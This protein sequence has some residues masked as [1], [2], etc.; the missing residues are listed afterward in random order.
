[1]SEPPTA[2]YAQDLDRQ[3]AGSIQAPDKR[4]QPRELLRILVLIAALGI[5]ALGLLGGS[6]GLLLGL[7]G[8]DTGALDVVTL[9]IS[10]LALTVGLG[11]LL[12][13]HTGSAIRGRPSPAFRPARIGLLVLLFLLSLV[14]GQVIL[15]QNLLPS[16]TFPPFHVAATILPAFV[17]L[18]LVGRGLGQ[19]TSRRDIVLQLA[20]GAF[21][22]APLAF[23]LEAVALLSLLGA[24]FVGLAARPGGQELL[25]FWSTYLQDPVQLQESIVLAPLLSSPTLIAAVIVF[26][27]GIVPLIEEGV[28]TV[29]VGLMGYRKPNISQ[30]FLWGLAGGAGF[31]IVEGL[32]NTTGGFEAWA[33]LVLVRVGATLL[34]CTTG[35]LMGI[36]WYNTLIKRRWARAFGLYAACVAVHGLWNAL[37]IGMVFLSLDETTADPAASNQVMTG[38]GI[39]VLL[40]LLATLGLVMALSLLGLTL[41]LRKHRQPPQPPR[42]HQPFPSPETPLAPD[43]AAETGRAKG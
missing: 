39:V 42:S 33:P 35:A 38:L 25:R 26:V 20:S 11:L 40:V 22:G 2:H 28:K 7:F 5:A 36:A 12:A 13:W 1:M 31:A 41:H 3:A 24:T 9:S 30:A 34:H 6:I 27:A 14:I 32:L 15:S 18:A 43:S 23:A 29:G 21:L 4:S 8:Q 16:L 17:I 37:S 10:V 19:I